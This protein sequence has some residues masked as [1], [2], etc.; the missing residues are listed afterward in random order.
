MR[1][2]I[3]VAA[4]LTLTVWCAS[5]MP[6]V[7][8]RIVDNS[9]NDRLTT[10][11]EQCL[12]RQEEAIWNGRDAFVNYRWTR[13]VM[14][15]NEPLKVKNI[16]R[17][18]A[19]VWKAWCKAN[20]SMAMSGNAGLPTLCRLAD[21]PGSEWTLP[22]SLEPDAAMSFYWGWK[23]NE[24]D[25][26]HTALPLYLYL[27]GSGPRDS[28]WA[29]GKRLATQFD[30]APSIYFIP[31]IPNEGPYY[32]W[33]QLA[34]QYAWERLLRLALCN[35]KI[36]ANR[37][38]VFGISEGGYGSQRLA[39]FYADYW[40]AA[41]PMAGGEPLRNAPPEN[42]ANIGFSLLTGERDWG[43][44][45][46]V[47]T[48]RAKEAFDS[49]QRTT[50]VNDG[51]S[52]LFIHR[53]ELQKGMGHGID[54]SLD[55]PWLKNFKRNPWPKHVMWEDY[56][57]DGRHR[58]AF[59]NISVEKIPTGGDDDR[60][61]YTMDI[62]G[63]TIR[64]TISNVAYT[65]VERDPTWGI[66]LKTTKQYSRASGG[67]IK[68]FLNRQLADLN[69]KVVVIVNDT[70]HFEGKP[71]VNAANLVESC[72]LWGDPMRL[73]PAAVSIAY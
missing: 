64:M 20:N 2:N 8:K 62:V 51:D 25:T 56:A 37:I 24:A 33:W 35:P 28:E 4:G 63:D 14:A 27:H 71:T 9:E 73:F 7:G 18:R 13:P 21:S 47:L 66:E 54:Y 45:R 53:I 46:N 34:K 48:K 67:K 6:A 40:A 55:T 36:D 3:F 5:V 68:I 69:K 16:E 57:M 60:T 23:G 11:F 52:S 10:Y 29:A 59:Y 31:R 70:V 12:Q 50:K 15:L 32:R 42:C 38:Y 41:G 49:L 39:S 19:L 43:F 17:M 72:L 44:Y 58:K 22:S 26:M 61:A 30:D 65:V 1:I